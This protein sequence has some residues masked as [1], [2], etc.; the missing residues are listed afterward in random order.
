MNDRIQA[1]PMNNTTADQPCPYKQA[2]QALIPVASLRDNPQFALDGVVSIA[3]AALKNGDTVH[4]GHEPLMSTEDVAHYL[5]VPAATL[6]Q[7][8]HRGTGPRSF[9][10]GRHRRYRREDVDAWLESDDA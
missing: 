2:L 3:A 4:G 7:W 10:V 9:I 8:T 5:N 6:Y 1:Q